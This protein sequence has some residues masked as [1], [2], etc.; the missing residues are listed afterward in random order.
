MIRVETT[1]MMMMT[2]MMTMALMM[3]KRKAPFATLVSLSD[4]SRS[5]CLLMNNAMNSLQAI[6][7]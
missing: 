4:L 3:T 6:A 5:S 1:K 7:G 2:R